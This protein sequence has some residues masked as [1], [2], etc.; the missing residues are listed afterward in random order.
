MDIAVYAAQAAILAPLVVAITAMVLQ[1][2]S[3][4][5]RYKAVL[6]WCIGILLGV[7]LALTQSQPVAN[8]AWS[9]GI[10]GLIACGLYGIGK[11]VEDAK[12]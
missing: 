2:V 10:A 5:T 3:L 12:G 6:A 7:A 9:G 4:P 11:A 8:G 1:A